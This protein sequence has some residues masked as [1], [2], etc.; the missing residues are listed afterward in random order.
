MELLEMLSNYQALLEKKDALAKQTKDNNAAIEA[1]KEQIT[2]QMI[3]DDCPKISTGGY[4][5]SLQEKTIYSKRSEAD[6]AADGVDFFDTLRE[7]GLGDII[8]ETV[9]TQTL[10]STMRAYVEEH[11]A[12]SDALG[13]VINTYE[14]FDIYRR[15]DT[16]K[17]GKAV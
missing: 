9:T 13:K 7:E 3:D 8:K 16:K 2:Q 5:F 6:M 15:K 14:T 4:S 12:L 10:G 1:A 11:G 17:G